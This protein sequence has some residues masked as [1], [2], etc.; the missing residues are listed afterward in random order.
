MGAAPSSSY[1]PPSLEAGVDP[2]VLSELVF[3]GR[4]S[5]SVVPLLPLFLI[6][7][8]YDFAGRIDR[9][10]LACSITETDLR[11]PGAASPLAGRL[12]SPAGLAPAEI[13]PLILFLHGGGFTIGSLDSHAPT[14][15]FLAAET[16]FRVLAVEYR[17]A[18]EAP[19]PAAEDDVVAAYAYAASASSA[20]T[21]GVCPQSPQLLVCGDSAGG[22]LTI[23]VGLR[24]RDHNRWIEAAE[25]AIAGAE[26]GGAAA[27]PREPAAA[28]G[29]VAPRSSLPPETPRICAPVALVPFYPAIN[30][31][32]RASRASFAKYEHGYILNRSLM[33]LFT[34][35]YVPPAVV[36]A[37]RVC[38]Y[39]N[40]DLQTDLSG[41]PPMLL[42][43]AEFDVLHDEGVAFVEYMRTRGGSATHIEARG[44]IHGFVTTLKWRAAVNVVREAARRMV[45]AV[46]GGGVGEDAALNGPYPMR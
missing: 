43:T 24:I 19:W 4:L 6:R 39:L 21:L 29:A 22:Q 12:Y 38:S 34:R 36:E 7:R 20:A 30:S 25:A 32:S 41:L 42:I 27:A 3:S 46:S 28:A 16:R 8:G 35:S 26:S 31:A 33:E 18:P 1:V 11:I 15:R 37:C 2:E 14:C 17:L 40:A 23:A 13:A 10:P 9:P 5:D 44:L 45:L